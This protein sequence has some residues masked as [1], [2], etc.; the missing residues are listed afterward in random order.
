[1]AQSYTALEDFEM[2]TKYW[3]AALPFFMDQP[4]FLKPA[5]YY[6]RGEG[7]RELALQALQ[8]YVKLVPEDYDMVATLQDEF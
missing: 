5:Y 8:Q 7:E 1:M 3:R 6:F 4:D 2:A